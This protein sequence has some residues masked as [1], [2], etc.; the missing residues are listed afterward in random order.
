LS[1]G[2]SRRINRADGSFGGVAVGTIR[3]RYLKDLF[4]RFILGPNDSITLLRED[5][6][7]LM[8]HPFDRAIIGRSL[9]LSDSIFQDL[10]AS[11]E[12]NFVRN[13]VVDGVERLFV[14][15]S[16]GDLAL[17]QVVG[18][19]L[20]DV[21][22]PWRRKA[23][24]IAG[25]V[26]ILC[27]A[28]IALTLLLDAQLR[29]RAAVELRLTW[30]ANRDPLTGLANR[31]S[32]DETLSRTCSSPGCERKP[33][34]L[35]MLD[36]DYFKLYNDAFGHPKGDNVLRTIAVCVVNSL[37]QSDDLAV[38]YGGEEFV[39]LLPAVD[40]SG[41]MEVA[42][43]IRGAVAERC[44]PHSRSPLGHVTVSIGAATIVPRSEDAA[45]DLLFAA[46]AALYEA[47][48]RGRNICIG[49]SS[50][51]ETLMSAA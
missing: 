1:I 49:P 20:D 27:F 11:P 30:L 17:V 8:R 46:D 16:I 35:L 24:A 12:G 42:E 33:L 25:A 39:V 22:A 5:S 4:G 45:N 41:A 14:Y 44:L 15:G 6:V 31:R 21:V 37:R 13:S 23:L 2:L 18:F 43:R 36:V 29:A 40:L 47:K 9:H 28:M 34:S 3:L 26:A 32:F 38:R 48:K 7:V 50:A 19:A 10:K 51:R